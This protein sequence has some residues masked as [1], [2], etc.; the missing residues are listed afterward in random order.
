M[1]T[2]H[3]WITVS[4]QKDSQPSDVCCDT[5]QVKQSSLDLLGPAGMHGYGLGF[6]VKADLDQDGALKA[7]ASLQQLSIRPSDTED[8]TLLLQA[9]SQQGIQMA[10]QGACNNVP[11]F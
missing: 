5:I 11:C 10:V 4:R 1:R 8:A 2:L 9:S 6:A 3:I 7:L